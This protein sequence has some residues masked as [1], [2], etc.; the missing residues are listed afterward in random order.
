MILKAFLFEAV[1]LS[2]VILHLAASKSSSDKPVGV[3]SNARLGSWT[4]RYLSML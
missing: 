4:K 2:G 3:K 1:E